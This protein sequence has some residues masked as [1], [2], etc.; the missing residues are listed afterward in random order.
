MIY[1]IPKLV[2]DHDRL[3]RAV[4]ALSA[5]GIV[6]SVIAIFRKPFNK[7]LPRLGGLLVIAL[8]MVVGSEV[9]ASAAR[10]GFSADRNR[11]LV[12]LAIVAI[13]YY[14]A[15]PDWWSVQP[16]YRGRLRAAYATRRVQKPAGVVVQSLEPREDPDLGTL[17]QRPELVVCATMNV[18]GAV[19]TRTGV[20][21]Y[22]FTFSPSAVRLHVP[23]DADG[24]STDFSTDTASYAKVFRRWDTPR[25][26]A[27]TAAGISGAAV[28][29]AMGRFNY[30]STRALLT[31]A[32]VRLG[33][34]LPNPR[35]LTADAERLPNRPGYPRRRIGYLL[36][37]LFHLY[38]PEDLYVYLT[39]G[40]HWENLGVVEL[41]R[42]RCREIFCVDASGSNAI[43]FGTIAEAITLA[44]EECGA[45][46]TLD[47]ESL[48]G[49]SEGGVLPRTVP[50]DCGFGVIGYPSGPPT[51]LWYV[52]ASLTEDAAS[53][54]LAYHEQEPIFPSD[55]TIDQLYDAEKFEAYRLLGQHGG[56]HLVELRTNVALL[57][58]GREARSGT[59]LPTSFEYELLKGLDEETLRYL[60]GEA[61]AVDGSDRPGPGER[62]IDDAA[63]APEAAEHPAFAPREG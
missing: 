40:G 45:D 57:A 51:L 50:R 39:D 49:L 3:V 4:Q 17:T 23:G 29:S 47:F 36:K 59:Y 11:W 60:G 12:V 5:G 56:S 37:E 20:P 35:Y 27:I 1:E 63:P 14:V 53:R 7:A 6:A 19:P 46:V 26:T 15:D 38:D 34:W 54:L 41:V 52:K 62:V 33:M 31:L 44:A 42:R 25:L 43:S 48:R 10:Q 8:A 22:S 16:Y 21:A 2:Q 28:S 32:N 13:W 61:Q 55:S 58:A 24:L 9:A 18:S 30:G